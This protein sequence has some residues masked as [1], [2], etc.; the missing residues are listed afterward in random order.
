MKPHYQVGCYTF[1]LLSKFFFYLC[2]RY[3]PAFLKVHKHKN[4]FLLFLQK[5][6]PYGPKGL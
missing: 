4:F 1:F 6:N 5:S 3:S 2:E